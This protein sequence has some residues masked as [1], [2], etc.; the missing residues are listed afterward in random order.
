M[1]AGVIRARVMTVGIIRAA[2][3]RAVAVRPPLGNIEATQSWQW[4]H[5][6]AAVGPSTEVSGTAHRRQ[7]DCPQEA[8][9][10]PTGDSEAA[11]RRQ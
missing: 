1:K 3:M 11:H 6:Q 5:P 7:W 4:H 8:V 10:P 2:V 9:G